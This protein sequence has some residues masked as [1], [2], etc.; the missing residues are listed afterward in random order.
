MLIERLNVTKQTGAITNVCMYVCMSHTRHK[1][2]QRMLN[3]TLLH[4][5]FLSTYAAEPG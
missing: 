5:T 2:P 3:V 1:I 4:L